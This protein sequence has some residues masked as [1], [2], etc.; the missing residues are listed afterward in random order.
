M[1]DNKLV[2]DRLPIE[3]QNPPSLSFIFCVGWVDHFSTLSTTIRKYG[4][5][6]YFAIVL[7]AAMWSRS[8]EMECGDLG[9]SVGTVL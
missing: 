3:F 5:F 6:L 8:M 9:K 1:L 7:K 2:N 4:H